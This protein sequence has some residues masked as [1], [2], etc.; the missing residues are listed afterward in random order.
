MIT[1]PQEKL[2]VGGTSS[3]IDDNIGS[4]G[5]A[6]ISPTVRIDGLNIT[7]NASAFTGADT[8]VP[9]YVDSNGDTSVK[10]GLETFGTYTLPGAD[11]IAANATLNVAGNGTY[12]STPNLLSTSFTLKQRSVVYISSNLSA[13]VQNSSGGTLSDGKAR[14]IAAALAFTSAPASSGI[15]TSASYVVDEFVFS[16]RSSNSVNSSFKLNPSCELVLPAGTYT[17]ALSGRGAASG[18]ASDAFRIVFGSGSGD[19]LNVLARPL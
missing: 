16:N 9:L 2:H 19:K 1:Q 11:A 18:Y 12:A 7:N 3:I 4:T 13:N 17:I 10:K 14:I 8:T 15:D 6:L 5:T